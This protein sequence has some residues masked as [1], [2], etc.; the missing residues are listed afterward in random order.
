MMAYTGSI[1]GLPPFSIFLVQFAIFYSSS[2]RCREVSQQCTT[3][4]FSVL[5]NIL[6][7]IKTKIRGK[8][9][10]TFLLSSHNLQT[11]ECRLPFCAYYK[12]PNNGVLS[13]Y[14]KCITLEAYEIDLPSIW[15]SLV[16][17]NEVC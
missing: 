5:G 14:Q 8:L 9:L 12:Q 6:R 4:S 1:L 15:G 2:V 13:N 10:R 11:I 17:D 7:K 3:E 16:M